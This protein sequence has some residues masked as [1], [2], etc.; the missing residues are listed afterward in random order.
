MSKTVRREFPILLCKKDVLTLSFLY[1]H[2]QH[3]TTKKKEMSI[4]INREHMPLSLMI[5][6]VF[7]FSV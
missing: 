4:Y 6:C 1:T 2:T 3:P 7:S 5:S